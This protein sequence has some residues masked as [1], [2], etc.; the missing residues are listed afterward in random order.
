[1]SEVK[2]INIKPTPAEQVVAPAKPQSKPK[3]KKAPEGSSF[4]LEVSPTPEYVAHRIAMF[5]DLKKKADEVEAA[6]PRVPI[7]IAMPDGSIREGIAWETSPMDIAKAISK[8][9]S[10]RVVIAK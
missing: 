8:S 9:L 5:D 2:N 10:E 3:V 1:M 4:P 6:Q 7:S